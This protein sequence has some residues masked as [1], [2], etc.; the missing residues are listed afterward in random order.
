MQLK[1]QYNAAAELSTVA[2]Q[3][4]SAAARTHSECARSAVREH[5]TYK[6]KQTIKKLTTKKKRNTINVQVEE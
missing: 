4:H 6:R 1:Q 2:A 3:R 5:G